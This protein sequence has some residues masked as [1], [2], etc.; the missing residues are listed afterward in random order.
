MDVKK[1]NGASIKDMCAVINSAVVE[2]ADLV[3]VCGHQIVG[4]NSVEN[5][6]TSLDELIAKAKVKANT[7]TVGSILPGTVESDRQRLCDVN[8]ILKAKCQ[9]AQVNFIDH[10]NNFLFRDGT[11]DSSV[12]KSDGVGLSVSGVDRLLKNV[13][14]SKTP[15]PPRTA[16]RHGNARQDNVPRPGSTQHRSNDQRGPTVKTQRTGNV[17]RPSQACSDDR[18]QRLHT[19]RHG[20]DKGY[21]HQIPA[22]CNRC[23]ETNHV[24]QTCRHAEKVLCYTCGERGHKSK[25]HT[26]ESH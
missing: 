23:G 24:T 17:P 3:L 11:C 4:D 13:S 19:E 20:N 12:Y 7:V 14:L 2:K 5:I 26:H 22:Q 15:Q 10:D 1:T 16:Q 9:A 6:G 25:H 8:K 21:V 18:G